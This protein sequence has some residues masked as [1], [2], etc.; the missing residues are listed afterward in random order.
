MSP[1]G[2]STMIS[3][4]SNV[5]TEDVPELSREDFDSMDASFREN[6]GS[7]GG[8]SS[9]DE[10]YGPEAPIHPAP[11]INEIGNQLNNK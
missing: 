4:D 10:G 5:S 3:T 9:T 2:V 11:P 8:H 6:T 1:I 7:D